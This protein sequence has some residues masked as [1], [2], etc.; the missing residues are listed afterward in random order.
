M[1][2]WLLLFFLR[3]EVTTPFCQHFQ[4]S[5]RTLFWMSLWC[6]YCEFTEVFLR[7]SDPHDVGFAVVTFT[8]VFLILI[9]NVRRGDLK[10]FLIVLDIGVWKYCSFCSKNNHSWYTMTEEWGVKAVK[11]RKSQV[12]NFSLDKMLSGQ[13]ISIGA[14]WGYP[15][16]MSLVNVSGYWVVET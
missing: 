2:I 15:R 3:F 8:K 12:Y 10:L 6:H 5:F 4:Q 11:S 7:V 16:D 9:E 1:L 14:Y 13:K